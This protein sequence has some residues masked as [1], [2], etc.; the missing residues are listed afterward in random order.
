MTL[1]DAALL[2]IALVAGFLSF[3]RGILVLATAGVLVSA[4]SVT[5][6]LL[7]ESQGIS[8]L[9]LTLLVIFSFNVGALGGLAKALMAQRDDVEAS[10]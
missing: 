6:K 1:L 7:T 5:A 4:A 9:L 2:L 3:S 8:A 10:D